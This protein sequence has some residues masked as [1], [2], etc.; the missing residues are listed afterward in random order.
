MIKVKGEIQI[1][2]VIADLKET[3]HPQEGDQEAEIEAIETGKDLQAGKDQR[4]I[5]VNGDVLVTVAETGI[6]HARGVD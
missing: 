1:G 4:V 5:V 2:A 6:G 3:N